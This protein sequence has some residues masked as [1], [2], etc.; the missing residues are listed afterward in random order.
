MDTTVS[1][2]QSLHFSDNNHTF[3][4]DIQK[5][6]EDIETIRLQMQKNDLFHSRQHIHSTYSHAGKCDLKTIKWKGRTLTQCNKSFRYWCSTCG[7]G[8][9][10]M[11]SKCKLC[12]TDASNKVLR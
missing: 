4:D 10:G 8:V 2:F 12:E 6:E 11:F 9:G 1:N 7:T 3:L 5:N